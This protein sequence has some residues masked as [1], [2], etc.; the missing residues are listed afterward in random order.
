MRQC[1]VRGDPDIVADEVEAPRV[2]RLIRYPEVWREG[3]ATVSRLSVED[4][5]QMVLRVEPPV[6][7][8]DA[9][10]PVRYRHPGK[11]VIVGGTIIIHLDGEAPGDT[12]V[13][14]PTR[15]DFRVSTL[16]VRPGHVHVTSHIVRCR[17]RE[18]VDPEVA[19]TQGTGQGKI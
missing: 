7:E 5:Y 1:P 16:I 3:D 8:N 4:I 10:E 12:S 14:A 18:T 19:I 6:V 9:E 15:Q 11:E 17:G 2:R 13:E